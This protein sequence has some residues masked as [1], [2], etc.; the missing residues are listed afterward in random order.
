M[1]LIRK[2]IEKINQKLFQKS[3]EK[4]RQTDPLEYITDPAITVVTM[5]SH[6]TVDMYLV[7]LKSFMI[8]FGNASI[9][10]INDGSLS[11]TDIDTLKHH[12]P[13]ISISL[14]SETDTL[15]CPDYISWKRL[16]RIIEISQSS[17]AIQLDSDTIT[18]AP[19]VEVYN[20]AS[21]NS[22]FMIGAGNWGELADLGFLHSI[23]KRWNFQHPQALAERELHTLSFFNSDDKYLHGCAGFAGYPKGSL[24]YEKVQDLSKQIGEKISWEVWKSWGSEQMATNCLISKCQD[25][26]ILPWPKYRNYMFPATNDPYS[27]AAFIHFIGT[28]RYSDWTYRNAVRQF[29]KK[30]A[31]EIE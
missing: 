21:T 17:F 12:I 22:G 4:I 13:G 15:D 31:G 26:S 14:A 18:L 25:A 8:H 27:A 5:V 2:S 16:F 6:N 20:R 28:Y 3:C 23:A 7:A 29:I 30:Y 9:E 19:L 24:T 10:A 11:S 1:Y